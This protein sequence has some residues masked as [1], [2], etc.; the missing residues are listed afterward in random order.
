MSNTSSRRRADIKSWR[1]I[2][3]D[4]HS[5]AI[6]G[7]NAAGPLA[8]FLAPLAEIVTDVDVF[9]VQYPLLDDEARARDA[10][11]FG[12]RFGDQGEQALRLARARGDLRTVRI[13]DGYRAYASLTDGLIACRPGLTLDTP[14]WAE[15]T[16]DRRPVN[17]YRYW[18][19]PDE[20][21]GAAHP[22][23]RAAR[24]RRRAEITAGRAALGRPAL[25]RGVPVAPQP[26][27]PGTDT[28]VLEQ[29]IAALT[30]VRTG[31]KRLAVA[32]LGDAL[33]WQAKLWMFLAGAL[34]R[35]A[36][37]VQE[38]KWI[39]RPDRRR[40]V[41]FIGGRAV[42]Q[43]EFG[44]AWTVELP[45]AVMFWG[46]PDQDGWTGATEAAT[47]AL[48]ARRQEIRQGR[49]ILTARGVPP[50]AAVVTDYMLEEAMAIP[51][52]VAGRPPR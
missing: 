9:A 17:G 45:E 13:W 24:K 26:Y 52:D 3:G 6:H 21:T 15:P 27:P 7:L 30:R 19:V 50:A 46:N 16:P 28:D 36:G 4:S 40:V 2:T 33:F 35:R 44:G 29:L 39:P 25:P 47:A 49:D 37:G 8:M 1:T 20:E 32:D 12:N 38:M 41:C 43:A 31:L 18:H 34:R 48:E 11:E 23:A 14:P 51:V 22:V 5:A 42:V 10:I